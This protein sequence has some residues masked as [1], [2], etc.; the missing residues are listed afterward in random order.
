MLLLLLRFLSEG[1]LDWIHTQHHHPELIALTQLSFLITIIFNLS[2]HFNLFLRLHPRDRYQP[3][4]GE[5]DV[6]EFGSLPRGAIFRRHAVLFGLPT[7][8]RML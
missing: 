5:T 6:L 8:I 1:R 2:F 7:C 4:P 3:F